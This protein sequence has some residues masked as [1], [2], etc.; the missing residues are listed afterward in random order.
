MQYI[1]LECV[2]G[3]KTAMAKKPKGFNELLLEK[4]WEA[5]TGKSLERLQSRVIAESGGNMK[6][7]TTSNDMVKIST[8]LKDLI[9]PY[10]VFC[11]TE[12]AMNQL[13]QIGVLAW[14]LS[15]TPAKGKKTMRKKVMAFMEDAVTAEGVDKA[16]D[17]LD[18]LLQRKKE[19]FPDD[20]RFIMDFQLEYTAKG[21]YHIAA[22]WSTSSP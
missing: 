14:N 9:E 12:E 11:F 1:S 2:V 15:I 18:T 13:L 5:A 19:L 21:F 16:A 4:R 7:V 17:F 22:A 10:E 6:M 20:K 3:N 8:A